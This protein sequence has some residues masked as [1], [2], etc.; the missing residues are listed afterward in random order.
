MTAVRVLL[1][2]LLI[3]FYLAGCSDESKEEVVAAPNETE[4]EVLPESAPEPGL[5]ELIETSQDVLPG[6][7]VLVRDHVADLA[8][9]RVGILTNPT[10]VTRNLQSTIDAVRGMPGVEVVRLF[11]PEHGLRGQHYAGDKVNEKV[12][13]VS[14]LPV[15][16]LYGATRR[17]TPEM[18]EGL[19]VILYDIQD[20]GHRTYTFVS[21]LTYLME[22]CEK[23]GVAVW[24]LDRPDPT[25]GFH[26]GGPVIDPDLLSFIGIHEVPQVYGMTP[27]EWAQMV[28]AERT[29]DIDLKVIT[30]DGWRRGMTFGETGWIWVPTSQ[31]IPQW[32]TSY[33]YGMTGTLGELG[34]VN[35]GVGTPNPFEFIG[36]EWL[37]GQLFAERL[38]ALGVEG[39]IF[40]PVSYSPRYALGSGKMLHGVQ[41]HIS[42][43]HAVN[44]ASVLAALISELV[45]IAPERNLFA[46]YLKEDGSAT[47]FLKALGDRVMAEQLATN[48]V[49]DGLLAGRS[50]KL[51]AFLERRDRYLLYP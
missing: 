42:D 11:S 49:P 23:A 24:V 45:R 43:Y 12:D 18:L 48:E 4:A 10:G 34:K 6:V 32:T 17:P 51:E 50:E 46:K 21:S 40:R 14:G 20:V 3:P 7:E 25:G 19:D 30:M 9:K 28:K 47:G 39:V 38:N 5:E 36:A 33:F 2:T 37:D 31:H 16:S 26:V 8:G 35:V 29:P 44:P 13:P 41:I 15:M 1:L 22:E 27:G